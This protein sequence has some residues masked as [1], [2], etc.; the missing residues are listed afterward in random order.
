MGVKTRNCTRCKKN[1]ALR[2][3][4]PRGKICSGCQRQGRSKAT[5]E[6]RVQETYGLLEGEW[7]KLFE[8]QGRVCAICGGSRR[9]RLDTDH[10]HRTGTVRGLICASD[11]RKILKYAKDDPERL[12]RAADYLENPPAIDVLGIRKAPGDATGEELERWKEIPDWGGWYEVSNLG[13]VRSWVTHNQYTEGPVRRK[14]P[15]ILKGIEDRIYFYVN[16]CVAG[17]REKIGIHRLVL[18]VFVGVPEEG[19]VACHNNGDGHDNRLSNLR[20]DTAEGNMQDKYVHGTIPLGEDHHAAIL[21]EEDV[22]WARSVYMKGSK[23]FGAAAL[24]RRLGVTPTT[25][26]YALRGKSWQH[27]QFDFRKDT[28]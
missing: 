7:D 2:F 5:H 17:K 19:Q 14:S 12:R 28:D 18:L 9:G 10:D 16:L 11:N 25:L 4:S 27:I 8:A 22:K 21:T 3:F 20:W 23:E 13:R 1:R 26:A 15:K 24:S 6:A